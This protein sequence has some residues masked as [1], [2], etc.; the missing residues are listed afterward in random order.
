MFTRRRK[1]AHPADRGPLRV[2]FVITSMPVGGAETLL[3][4][5]VRRM[6][7]ERFLPELCCL[8]HFDALG[9]ELAQEIPAFTG[10]LAH[11]YDF[12]V[13]GRLTRLLRGR[14]IDAVVTVGTGGDKMFW[15]RLAAWRAGTPVV[16]SALHS[17]G[18]PDHVEWQNRLLTPLTDAFIAVAVPH[19][20]HLVEHE[21]C[22]AAKVRVVPNGVDTQR[23][24]PLAPSPALREQLR[25]P[26]GAPVAAILAALRPEKNHELFLRSAARIRQT[27]PSAQFLVI[28]DGA[29]RNELETLAGQLQLSPSV[30]FLGTRADVPEL[31]SLVDVL[32]LSSHMEA[33]PVSVLEALACEKPVVATR[34]GSVGETVQDGV[35]GYLVARGDDEEMAARVVELFGNPALARDM[36]RAGRDHVVANWSL[37]RMVEGYQDLIHDIYSGKCAAA[38]TPVWPVVEEGE[39]VA[40][41]EVV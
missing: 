37:E 28:G 27:V 24:R 31:L 33:N 23:F 22:P 40:P 1:P 26:P 35:S 30:H 17:T 10:L 18:L 9:D 13:L 39:S 7:R 38:A 3:V 34:V 41:A 8:K 25:L 29:R 20:R 2:M 4:N 16:A 5:L 12:R 21:G 32:V 11:K 15:G 36:G 19:A 14:R 6:D